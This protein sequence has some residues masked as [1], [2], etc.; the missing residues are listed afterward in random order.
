MN[1]VQAIWSHDEENGAGLAC[2]IEVHITLYSEF[3]PAVYSYDVAL[4]V[5]CIML[6]C[7]L[8]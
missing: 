2:Q 7:S 4:L 5:T 6:R 3:G 1:D 8:A